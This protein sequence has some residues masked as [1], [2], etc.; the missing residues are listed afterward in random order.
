MGEKHT[1]DH[2]LGAWM[3]CLRAARLEPREG[4]TE[5]V[6]VRNGN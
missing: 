2:R 5:K 1:Q 3:A 4:R 6:E